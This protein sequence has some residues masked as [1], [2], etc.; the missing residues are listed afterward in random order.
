M[1]DFLKVNVV[2]LLI[3]IVTV[4]WYINLPQYSKTFLLLLI[5]SMV[6]FIINMVWMSRSLWK[7]DKEIIDLKKKYKDSEEHDSLYC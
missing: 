1:K 5:F 3:H 4:I 6:V 7:I 2:L